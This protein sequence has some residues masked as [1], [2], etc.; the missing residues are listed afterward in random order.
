MHGLETN[1]NEGGQCAARCQKRE[2]ERRETCGQTGQQARMKEGEGLRGRCQDRL[3]RRGRGQPNDTFA[4]RA[5]SGRGGRGRA[6]FRHTELYKRPTC[7]TRV[8]SVRSTRRLRY[9]T[10][11]T[12]TAAKWMACVSCT[13]QS[14]RGRREGGAPGQGSKTLHRGSE[15]LRTSR[16]R[17]MGR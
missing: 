13:F 6:S 5:G 3:G 9:S 8:V 11:T 16:T 4:G 7:S 17:G 10:S 14:A 1:V 2:R 15:G 12:G